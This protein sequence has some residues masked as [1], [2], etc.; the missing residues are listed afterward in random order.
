MTVCVPPELWQLVSRL[1]PFPDWPPPDQAGIDRLFA[2]ALRQG[3]FG[4]LMADAALP[5]Q[6]KAARSRYRVRE[7]VDHLRCRRSLDSIRVLQQVLGADRVLLFKGADYRHRLYTPSHVRQMADVDILVEPGTFAKTLRE[8]EQAGYPTRYGSSIASHAPWAMEL[9]VVVGGVAIDVHRNFIY[10]IRANIDYMALWRRRERFEADGLTG[11]HLSPSDALLCHALS[12]LAI[13][14]FNCP[15]IRYVDFYLLLQRYSHEMAGCVERARQWGITRAFFGALHVTSSL[16]PSARS[17]AVADAM[18][19]LVSKPVRRLLI[20]HVLPGAGAR[21]CVP[22]ISRREQL[23]R[24]F[25]LID[26][27]WRRVAFL[28]YHC[29]ELVTGSWLRVRR[30]ARM[31]KSVQATTDLSGGTPAP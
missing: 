17:Q 25:W 13:D 23:W 31:A 9:D 18:Q 30:R 12:P 24:K 20:R 28:L 22:P 26:K 14:E 8:L 19:E 6:I 16:F 1:G 4:L 5:E 11:W 15:L 7:A 2:F 27:F 10:P 29:F 21:A 3:L